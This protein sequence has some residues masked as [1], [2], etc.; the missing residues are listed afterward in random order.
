MT[1]IEQL[2]EE[3]CPYEYFQY[4]TDFFNNPNYSVYLQGSINTA[5]S[6]NDPG[7]RKYLTDVKS[8]LSTIKRD[9]VIDNDT[10]QEISTLV[11][12]MLKFCQYFTLKNPS[13]YANDPESTAYTNMIRDFYTATPETGDLE[14]HKTLEPMYAIDQLET[15]PVVLAKWSSLFVK[16][17]GEYTYADMYA[18]EKY[19]G[20]V[21][22]TERKPVV[23]CALEYSFNEDGSLSVRLPANSI[24]FDETK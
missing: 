15:D 3:N 12:D 8:A 17:A 16:Y 23:R 13:K 20:Y 10:Y 21:D 18:D 22:K 7:L 11:E 9:K 19:Y 4:G 14:I 2:L 5:G 6:K 1:R 24:T